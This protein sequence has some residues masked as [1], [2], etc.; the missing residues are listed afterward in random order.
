MAEHKVTFNI[1]ERELGR[2][3]LEFH[4]SK[5]GAKLGALKVSKGKI[6]WVPKDCEKGFQMKWDAFGALMRENGDKKL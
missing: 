3:D 2:A 1:P 5:G 6:E 4:V